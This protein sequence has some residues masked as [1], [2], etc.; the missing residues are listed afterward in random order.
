M[1][2]RNPPLS[3]LQITAR[4]IVDVDSGKCIWRDATKH[5]ANLVGLEAGC[6]RQTR[7]GSSYWVIKI[8]NIPY[9]RAQIVL[10]MK[11]GI[12]PKNMVDHKNG[13]T[14]DDRGDN[15]RHATAE[16]NAWNHRG[17]T[18]RSPLPMG[19]R[20]LASGRFGARIRHQ[21]I[22]KSLGTFPSAAAAQA[23][24][25]HARKEIFGDYA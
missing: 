20:A 21:G 23:A 4:L 15:L 3:I 2:K 10:A 6:P 18:K 5:H 12:W 24:Y 25:I 17:R 7:H 11:T 8:D 16:Q 19:V 1:V 9:K 14:L 13:Q 22:T